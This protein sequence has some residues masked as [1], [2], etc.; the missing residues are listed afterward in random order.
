M[1]IDDAWKSRIED[2]LREIKEEI[3]GIKMFMEQS[4]LERNILFNK[5]S[6]NA[7]EAQ[8]IKSSGR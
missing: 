6:E 1:G 8:E 7:Y 2:I 5:C 3:G 4:K